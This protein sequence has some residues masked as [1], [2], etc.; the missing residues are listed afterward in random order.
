MESIKDREE[1]KSLGEYILYMENTKYLLACSRSFKFTPEKDINS[2]LK[3]WLKNRVGWSR[4]TLLWNRE[5][6]LRIL[7]EFFFNSGD[8]EW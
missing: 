8:K 4:I 1:F 7:E 6:L 5:Q 3:S 2:F